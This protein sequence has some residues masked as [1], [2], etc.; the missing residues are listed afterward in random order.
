MGFNTDG[1]EQ[2]A[3]KSNFIS[4]VGGGGYLYLSDNF[5]VNSTTYKQ[6]GY[7]PVDSELTQHHKVY[8]NESAALP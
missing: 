3:S 4:C 6:G 1:S 7:R 5:Y 8:C 2:M